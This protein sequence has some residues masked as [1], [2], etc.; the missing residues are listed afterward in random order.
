MRT[1][2]KLSPKL[3][4]HGFYEITWSEEQPNGKWRS[5]RRSTKTGDA[6]RAEEAL[7]KFL[8]LKEAKSKE[9]IRTLD[10]IS[11]IYIRQHS[12]PKGTERSDRQ[13]LRAPLGAF[14][15]W[16]A[17]KIED[18]DVEAYGYRRATGAYGNKPVAASTIRREIVALQAVLN[19]GSRKKLIPGN[20]VFRFPKPKDGER[21]DKWMN[22]E[23]QTEFL[24][25][26]KEASLDVRVFAHLGLTYGVRRGAI[27][28][29]R[30]GPMVNFMTGII[31]FQPPG[32]PVTRKRKPVVPMTKT[33]RADLE[34][35]YELKGRGQKV[36]A[37]T[38]HK[39]FKRFA[40]EAGYGWVTPHVLKHTAITLMLRNKISIEDVATM[41]ATDPRT[42]FKVYRHHTVDELRNIAEG[43][44]I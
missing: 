21:R 1:F 28:G 22:E 38:A 40:E 16:P 31:D 25:K 19:F 15:D 11:E 23:Q 13:N 30:F 2:P 18:G 44:G 9:R 37:T 26:L 6:T 17:S 39:M 27:L 32:A 36:V 24:E 7:A 20:P 42:I 5:K 4:A 10:D 41:T 29:L 33:V 34:E 8:V 35:M 43:R 3:N 12:K 14:G